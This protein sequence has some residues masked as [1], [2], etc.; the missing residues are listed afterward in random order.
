M[1]AML[2]RLLRDLLRERLAVANGV[3]K[4]EK[5]IKW[6]GESEVLHFRVERGQ[7]TRSTLQGMF[8]AY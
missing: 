2:R 8:E 1:P 4:N 7:E 3:E 6:L 5:E